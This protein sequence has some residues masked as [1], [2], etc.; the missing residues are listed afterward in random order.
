MSNYLAQEMHYHTMW[1]VIKTS[2]TR[3]HYQGKSSVTPSRSRDLIMSKLAKILAKCV[4][5]V[6]VMILIMSVV[7]FSRQR[8]ISAQEYILKD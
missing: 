2:L 4:L 7:I 1:P 6:G 3:S 5:C 8:S